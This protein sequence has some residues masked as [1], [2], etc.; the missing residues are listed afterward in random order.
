MCPVGAA[1]TLVTGH[2][3]IDTIIAMLLFI[4]P[5]FLLGNVFCSWACPVGTLI[6]S[7]DK[8]VEKFF[9][10]VEAKRAERAERR[11][12][13]NRKEGKKENNL[14]CPSCPINKIKTKRYGGLANGIFASALLGSAILKFPLF[15]AVCPMGILS[16]GMIHLR[17]IASITGQ[18]IAFILELLPIPIIAVLV[19]LRERRFWC[20]KLCPVG[21]VLNAAGALNPFIKLKARE[22]KCVMKGCPEECEDGHL[23]YC[24]YCR[25]M[26]DYKCEKV[27][28]VD[29]SLLN[30]DSLSRCTKCLE[31]Y[32]V[33]DYNAIKIDLMGKP[34]IFRIG[35]F[36]K[37]LKARRK[38]DKPI[39]NQSAS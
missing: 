18:K 5:I 30:H 32:I 28:P 38:K 24:T 4:I 6:D 33:C 26:D 36:F 14:V 3:Q 21:A 37:R 19:S 1:Q 29:I 20:K 10:K 22:E 15:C 34:E 9:P 13:N 2:V 31:C 39:E 17:S 12:Q 8:A 25:L 11:R 7:F 23:D 27:C 35:G 16:R